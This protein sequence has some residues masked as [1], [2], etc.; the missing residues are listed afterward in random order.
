MRKVALTGLALG[1]ARQGRQ[2]KAGRGRQAM[3]RG[4]AVWLAPYR[5]PE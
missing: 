3:R 2:G 4:R 1:A 5:R